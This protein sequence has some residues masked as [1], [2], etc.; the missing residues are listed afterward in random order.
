MK[1]KLQVHMLSTKPATDNNTQ[2]MLVKCIK[3]QPRIGE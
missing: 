2:G 3:E 1:K